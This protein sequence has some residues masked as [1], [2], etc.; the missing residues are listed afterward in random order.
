[1]KPITRLL[2]IVCL[3]APAVFALAEDASTVTKHVQGEMNKFVAACKKK[4]MKTADGVI[5]TNFS[6][7]CKLIGMDGKSTP[8]KAWIKQQDDQMKMTKSVTSMSLKLTNGSLKGNTFTGLESFSETG[9]MAN[10]K[11]PKKAS[12][13][14]V[15]GTAVMQMEKKNGKWWVTKR[16]E[17]SMSM[18][19]DGKPFRPSATKT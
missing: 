13:F 17:K 6:P 10:P 9:T 15:S 11:N 7:T 3:A 12:K 18:T 16:T 8:L 14:V 4:D 19:V 2:T 1:M 5:L